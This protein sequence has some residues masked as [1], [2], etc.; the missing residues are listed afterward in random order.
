M[1]SILVTGIFDQMFND[2]GT[3]AFGSLA[4]FSL[5]I[6]VIATVIMFKLQIPSPLIFIV[7]ALGSM[8]LFIMFSK[9]QTIKIILGI[10]GIILGTAIALFFM[11]VFN[12]G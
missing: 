3:I 10:V 2:V 11:R 6:I 7:V 4:L 12:D 5:V 8:G 9:D 1:L